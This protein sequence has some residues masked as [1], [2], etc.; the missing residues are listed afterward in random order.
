MRSIE[1]LNQRRKEL[2]LSYPALSMLSGV[3]TPTLQKVLSG[4][5]PS[6]RYQTLQKIEEALYSEDADFEKSLLREKPAAY[7]TEQSRE[8]ETALP[9]TLRL[10][11]KEQ[12]TL[13]IADYEQLP[14]DERYELIDGVLIRLEAPTTEHQ[15]LSMFLSA[16]LYLLAEKEDCGCTVLTAPCDVL[17]DGE[18]YDM[19]SPTFEHQRILGNLYLR[20][21]E[22]AETHGL[23]CDIYAAPCDV[24]LDKDNYTMVQPD[25]LVL[26]GEYDSAVKRYEGAPDLVAEILSPSTRSKDMLLKRYKYERAHVREFWVVD[27]EFRRVVVY[28]FGQNGQESSEHS[29]HF[30]DRIPIGIC[31]EGSLIDFG[32]YRG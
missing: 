19:A 26:C 1:E 10:L 17:I 24:Q 22:C 28:R 27:P 30:D 3:P 6:P 7:L 5:T 14:E 13:T 11:K 31:K 23:P 21:R 16:Q 18:I 29:Y 15:R 2:G 20:F 9:G 32:R 12:G 25:L 8:T 4:T